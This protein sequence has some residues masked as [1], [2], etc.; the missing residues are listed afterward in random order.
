M[1]VTIDA[2]RLQHELA[3][4]VAKLPECEAR[5]FWMREIE[6]LDPAMIC[7]RLGIGDERLA[8]LLYSARVA[9]C[10]ALFS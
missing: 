3:A 2:D 6:G 1:S 8:E 10:Q 9:L 7:A 4:Q 5:A